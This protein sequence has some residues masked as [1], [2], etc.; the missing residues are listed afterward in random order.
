MQTW[1]A[2]AYRNPP[3]SHRESVLGVT[4]MRSRGSAAHFAI[5]R[6]EN[7]WRRTLPFLVFIDAS[8]L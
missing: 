1:G 4:I 2:L 8:Q 5:G 7:L 6:L 3:L